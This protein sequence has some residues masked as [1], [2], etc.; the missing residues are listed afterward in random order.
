MLHS[1]DRPVTILPVN[2]FNAV[3]I[4]PIG[5][6]VGRWAPNGWWTWGEDARSGGE[7][8]Y[9]HTFGVDVQLLDGEAD[10]IHGALDLGALLL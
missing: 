10:I 6:V 4:G 3:P 8:L 9:S 2:L 7:M 1:R 5:H